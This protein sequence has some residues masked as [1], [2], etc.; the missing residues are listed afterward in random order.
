MTGIS[1]IKLD[2][3]TDTAGTATATATR[4]IQHYLEKVVVDQGTLASTTD[5]TITI[6]NGPH[7]ITAETVLTLTNHTADAIYYP[8]VQASDSVGAAIAG[9][10]DRIFLIGTPKVTIAQG[11]GV[12]SG[13]VILYF[14]SDR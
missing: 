11:G 9:A 1:E 6:E 8:R 7:G 12:T 10:Y 4:S 2:V 5:I 3:T 14:S 13:S